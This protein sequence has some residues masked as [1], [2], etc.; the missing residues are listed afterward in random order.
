MTK[1]IQT[2]NRMVFQAITRLSERATLISGD[3]RT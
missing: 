3:R 2:S 1:Y